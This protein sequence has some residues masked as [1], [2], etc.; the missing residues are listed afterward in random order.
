VGPKPRLAPDHILYLVMKDKDKAVLLAL[1]VAY[2]FDET[3]ELMDKKKTE[4]S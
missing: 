3:K 1:L 4:L 2:R